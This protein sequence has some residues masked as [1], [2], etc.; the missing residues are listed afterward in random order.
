[1][2][3]EGMRQSSRIT[4]A[5]WLART[6][7]LSSTFPALRPGVSCSTTNARIPKYP[8]FLSTVAKTTCRSAI[9]PFVMKRFTPFRTHCFPSFVA[10]VEMFATSDPASGS[11]RQRAP[12]R[13]SGPVKREEPLLL[14]VRPHVDD[15]QI[16]KAG[17][18][19]ARR[20]ARAPP[21]QLFRDDDVGQGRVDTTS[22][23][24]LRDERRVQA[25]D[26]RLPNDFPRDRPLA[27]V[28]QCE[29]PHFSFG[30]LMRG[31]LH[32]P[33]FVREFE[34]DHGLLPVAAPVGP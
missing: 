9:P 1:M 25:E 24:R 31:L 29:G 28:L 10:V 15:R 32:E 14:I 17:S 19:Q 34:I 5:V 20:H 4:S 30:E 23:V 12:S 6:P 16:G 26:V 22:P 3:P 18:D 8:R 2:F 33:L 21:V 7:I 13:A 11:V 27:V